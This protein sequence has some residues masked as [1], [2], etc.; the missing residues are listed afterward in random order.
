MTL[1]A[2]LYLATEAAPVWWQAGC[3]FQ[4]Q[5][6]LIAGLALLDKIKEIASANLLE[7]G[8]GQYEG[9]PDLAGNLACGACFSSR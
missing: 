1:L 5:C 9:T 8:Q 4:S 7:G 6:M 2:I 3:A